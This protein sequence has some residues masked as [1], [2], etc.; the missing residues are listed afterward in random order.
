[1]GLRDRFERLIGLGISDDPRRVA[2]KSR[3]ARPAARALR[4]VP[5]ARLVVQTDGSGPMERA[6]GACLLAGMEVE[7]REGAP[8]I[9]WDGAVITPDDLLALC[10]YR[11][12]PHAVLET[13]VRGVSLAHVHRDAA[14][15]AHE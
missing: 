10:V 8:E 9:R 15:A 4:S 7:I 2:V 11:G 3:Q 13:F 1:M 5:G 6:L 12:G 14:H